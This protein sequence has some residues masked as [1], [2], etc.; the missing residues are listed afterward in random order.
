MKGT[1]TQLDTVIY[2]SLIS[3]CAAAGEFEKALQTFD[4]MQFN[5]IS[6]D[7]ITYTSL[8]KAC[9]V[10]GSTQALIVGEEIF[11]SMQQRTNHFSTYIAPNNQTYCQ[12][13]SM[14]ARCSDESIVIPTLRQIYEQIKAKDIVIDGNVYYEFMRGSRAFEDLDFAL[15]MIKEMRLRLP[16]KFHYK[17]WSLTAMLLRSQSRMA[18]AE[19]FDK[20]LRTHNTHSLSIN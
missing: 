13:V 1:K 20:E 19:A 18:E 5:E 3:A 14:M 2:N 15:E 6:P 11:S 8:L 4:E 17:S 16:S 7:V 9:S 10:A 12:Y